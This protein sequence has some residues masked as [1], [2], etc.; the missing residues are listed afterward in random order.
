MLNPLSITI[1]PLPESRQCSAI[2]DKYPTLKAAGSGRFVT[3]DSILV[4]ASPS[5]LLR[6]IREHS[7]LEIVKAVS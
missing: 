6:N 5:Y 1:T 4:N 7:L 2:E 3:A